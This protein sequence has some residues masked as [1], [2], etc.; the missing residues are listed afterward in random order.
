M[1]KN[2]FLYLIILLAG[3]FIGAVSQVLLK[4]ATMQDYDSK[5]KEYLNARVLSAYILFLGTTLT[6]IYAYK[7]IPLSLGAVM[8]AAS[9]LFVALFDVVI[10]KTKINRR[11]I[12]ALLLIMGGIIVYAVLG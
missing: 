6:A 12:C 10:F 1:D 8:E 11:R 9:Y 2:E 5:I 4:K 3:I 7:G